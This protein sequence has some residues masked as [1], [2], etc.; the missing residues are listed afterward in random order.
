MLS[1]FGMVIDIFIPRRHGV[2]RGITFAR[3]LHQANVEKFL[4]KNL[5]IHIGGRML[6]FD[7][8]CQLRP[9]RMI[10]KARSGGHR[11]HDGGQNEPSGDQE[12]SPVLSRSFKDVFLGRGSNANQE[13]IRSCFKFTYVKASTKVWLDRNFVDRLR[14]MVDFQ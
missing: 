1:P 9:T 8:A 13:V 3:F 4:E 7:K 6:H 10:N 5:E 2:A 11:H 14:S 12:R